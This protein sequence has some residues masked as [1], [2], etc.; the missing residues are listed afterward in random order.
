MRLAKA[1]EQKKYDVRLVDKLIHE[2]KLTLDAHQ[3][4]LSNLD[5]STENMM[6]TEDE[7]KEETT[8]EVSE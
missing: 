7:K 3:K 1:L 2:G 5:D 6:Y 4:H 8:E